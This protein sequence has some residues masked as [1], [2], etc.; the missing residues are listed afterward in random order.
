MAE[1]E[2]EHTLIVSGTNVARPSSPDAATGVT[3]CRSSR[4]CHERRA[5]RVRYVAAGPYGQRAIF[6]SPRQGSSRRA[7]VV[8]D[9]AMSCAPVRLC[10]AGVL[11][12]NFHVERLVVGISARARDIRERFPC[13]RPF[14]AA[15]LQVSGQESSGAGSDPRWPSSS[16]S[17]AVARK[18]RPASTAFS[19]WISAVPRTSLE[20]LRS[21]NPQRRLHLQRHGNEPASSMNHR[22]LVD[23]PVLRCEERARW[24]PAGRRLQR[25]TWLA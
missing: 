10:I 18:G 25:S 1:P 2:R 20:P 9:T 13:A 11:A 8:P 16:R 19:C 15:R 6:Q 7:T 4:G 22:P 23:V 24:K 12:A 3:D 14:A 5:D 21:A 17:P